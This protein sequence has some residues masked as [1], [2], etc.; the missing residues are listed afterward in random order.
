[1]ITSRIKRRK[2]VQTLFNFDVV[3]KG[4]FEKTEATILHGDDLDLPTF[5][6]R[7]YSLN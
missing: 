6:R 3:S 7:G 5:I 2:P 4:R 1:M